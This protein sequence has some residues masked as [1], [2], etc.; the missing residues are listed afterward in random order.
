MITSKG[1]EEAGEA[2]E[3]KL[4]DYCPVPNPQSPIPNPQS[5]I[6]NLF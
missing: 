6:P 5:P 1:T 3:E 4:L 2:E